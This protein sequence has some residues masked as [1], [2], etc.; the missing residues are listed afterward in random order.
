M[1]R[2]QPGSFGAFGGA[3]PIGYESSVDSVTLGQFFNA[4]YAW[5]AVGL[6]LTGGVA[7]AVANGFLPI[8]MG[9]G[10]VIVL[11]IVQIALVIAIGN[12][13]RLSAT[14]ATAL[15]L[16]YAAIT[17]VML[18]MLFLIYTH[19]SLASTFLVTGGM[20]G[21]MSLYGFTTRR[22]LTRF[23]SFFFAALIGI[24]LASVVNIFWHNPALY[25]A[26]SYLGVLLFVGLTAYDTQRLRQ[27]AAQTANTPELAHRMAIV[28]SLMLYLDFINM[29]IFLLRIM[30]DRR[31]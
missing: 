6:A 7:F 1:S 14:A 25:W 10:T 24:I 11:F 3:G 26:V 18:S 19:A 20:F 4:V 23:G 29:F 22:D 9:L 17:G 31:R 16:L 8:P 27:V 21:A 30:G 28:G 5:M 12:P 13:T 15:F 2:F